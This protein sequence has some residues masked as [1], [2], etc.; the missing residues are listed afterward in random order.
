MTFPDFVADLVA[1]AK[2]ALTAL[3]DFNEKH[4][5]VVSVEADALK[6]GVTDLAAAAQG[7]ASVDVPAVAQP[8]VDEL[9]AGIKAEADKKIAKLQDADATL[10]AAKAAVA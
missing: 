8:T 10:Q 7:A 1:K 9:I 2:A 6:A 4:P 5:E 3:A